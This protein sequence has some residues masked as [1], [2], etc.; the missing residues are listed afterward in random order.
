MR[1][2][3][4]VTAGTQSVSPVTLEDRVP[5]P[6]EENK[7]TRG[8]N[9]DWTAKLLCPQRYLPRFAADPLSVMEM[10]MRKKS[11]INHTLWPSFVYD[12]DTYDENNPEQGLFRGRVIVFILR[13]LFIG[14]SAAKGC[15]RT[16]GPDGRSNA[17]L[18]ATA[19]VNG[20]MV[21]Y[22]ACQARFLLNAQDGWS[23][24]DYG[25][26]CSKF[27]D[28]IVK[29][30]KTGVAESDPV[31]METLAWLTSEVFHGGS[32][33]DDEASETD[34]DVEDEDVCIHRQRQVR[35]RLL[36]TGSNSANAA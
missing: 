25:F 32:G 30:F 15:R 6:V 33:Q 20:Y 19:K 10:G 4:K 22:V 36:R 21:A 27:Y 1:L 34:S 5:R 35:R 26:N 17:T 2:S 24:V 29:Y 8:W 14:P 9:H 28:R 3:R 7:L 16:K 13:H 23:V 11:K 12:T 18:I 31:V